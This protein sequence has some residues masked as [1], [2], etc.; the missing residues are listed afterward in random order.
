VE[1]QRGAYG[2]GDQEDDQ[3]FGHDETIVKPKKG[4]A[5]G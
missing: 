2:D 1:P 5:S 3:A 4:I